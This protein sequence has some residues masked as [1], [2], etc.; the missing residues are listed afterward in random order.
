[1][2]NV[3]E[4]GK[5]RLSSV[6]GQATSL[7]T[8]AAGAATQ[9]ASLPAGKAID[10]ARSLNPVQSAPTP[11]DGVG[12][13]NK[14][15]RQLGISAF[16]P[17]LGLSTDLTLPVGVGGAVAGPYTPGIGNLNIAGISVNAVRRGEILCGFVPVGVFADFGDK[18]GLHVAWFNLNTLQG[19]L[20]APL[21]GMIDTVL[22]AVKSHIKAAPIP[23]AT[24]N[25]PINTLKR[26]LSIVPSNGVRGGV[27]QTGPGLVLCAVY[28][29][30]KRGN[31]TY[32]FF[33]SIGI[34]EAR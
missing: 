9:A 14:L 5:G 4:K 34:T 13:A 12:A 24:Y 2:S 22:D 8:R 18:S 7:V 23:A 6:A 30:V 10:A 15:L 29:T 31:A 20:D 17:S 3:A 25:T 27:V 19:G 1:M 32:F 33:P 21:G 11:V 26:A 28:G 16:T